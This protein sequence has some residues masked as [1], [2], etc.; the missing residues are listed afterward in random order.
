MGNI[1]T[2]LQ[3]RGD[4]SWKEHPFN[5]IDN[6]VLAELSYLKLDGIVP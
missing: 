6:L 5:K 1:L 3:W 2:Y 4:L